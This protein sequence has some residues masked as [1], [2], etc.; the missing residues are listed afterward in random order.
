MVHPI[1]SAE[2]VLR[3]SNTPSDLGGVREIFQ[4]KNEEQL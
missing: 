3:T 4:E 1:F 2:Y